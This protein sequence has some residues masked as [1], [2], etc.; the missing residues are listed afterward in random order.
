MET[1]YTIDCLKC[2]GKG[3]C[4]SSE[5]TIREFWF[6]CSKCN[7]KGFIYVNKPEKSEIQL[8]REEIIELKQV[9]KNLTLNK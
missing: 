8:L 6:D 7:G 5:K 2:K 9:I 1:N 3:R 4:V